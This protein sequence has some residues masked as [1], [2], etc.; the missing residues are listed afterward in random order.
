MIFFLIFLLYVIILLF[1]FNL[2]EK[3]IPLSIIFKNINIPLWKAFIP[4]YSDYEMIK[5]CGYDGA[6]IG[7]FF[8]PVIGVFY[9]MFIRV[10]FA[11]KLNKPIF[12]LIGIALLP[13]VFFPIMLIGGFENT[14]VKCQNCG[15]NAEGAGMFCIKCGTKL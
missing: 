7:L 2:I 1:I 9:S 3:A 11:Q 12:V 13:V 14:K 10:K 5:Y 8:V 15:H 4:Y 6:T